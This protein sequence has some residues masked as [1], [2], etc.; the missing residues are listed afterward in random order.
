MTR[1]ERQVLE[2]PGKG[3]RNADIADQLQISTETA[4]THV[5]HVY[6]KLGVHSRAELLEEG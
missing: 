4:K 3:Q 1:R 5:K 6:S 2:L